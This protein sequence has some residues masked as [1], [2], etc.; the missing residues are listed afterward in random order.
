[1]K[2]M[3]VGYARVSTEEQNLAL[4]LD[5]LA[6][7]QQV[8]QDEGVSGAATAHSPSAVVAWVSQST[9]TTH[10]LDSRGVEGSGGKTRDHRTGCSVHKF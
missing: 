1:M 6:G 2:G 4:R 5:A 10:S 3:L 9:S 8:F 7:C